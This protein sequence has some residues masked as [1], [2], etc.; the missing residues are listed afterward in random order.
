MPKQTKKYVAAVA[1]CKAL[2]LRGRPIEA[3]WLYRFMEQNGLS[4]DSK[5]GCWQRWEKPAN[6]LSTLMVDVWLRAAL[7]DVERACKL[8]GG[9][10][11]AAGCQFERVSPPDLDDR[12]GPATTARVYMR[13][14]LPGE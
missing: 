11:Q 4:W 12:D 3:D 2:A 7:G 5:S 10:L 13:F 14:K 6:A 8:V 1:T 9:A